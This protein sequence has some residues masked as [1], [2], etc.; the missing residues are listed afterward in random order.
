MIKEHALKYYIRQ[1]KHKHGF[2]VS[3]TVII[4]AHDNYLE[5]L[6]NKY[7]AQP[8]TF[9]ELFKFEFVTQMLIKHMLYVDGELLWQILPE[10]SSDMLMDFEVVTDE[11]MMEY[12]RKVTDPITKIYETLETVGRNIDTITALYTLEQYF[13][14]KQFNE[15]LEWVQSL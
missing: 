1:S 3:D 6:L 13:I 10:H 5:W 7:E 9:D 12:E 15:A 4:Q 2:S 14:K 11:S 8:H